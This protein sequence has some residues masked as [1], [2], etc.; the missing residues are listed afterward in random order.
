MLPSRSRYHPSNAPVTLDPFSRIVVDSGSGLGVCPRPCCPSPT[1]T[2]ATHIASV[3]E[4]AMR[5]D[6]PT[7]KIA[8]APPLLTGCCRHRLETPPFRDFRF[9]IFVV[10]VR[11]V[12][13]RMAHLVDGAVAP[14]NPLIRIRIRFVPARVVVPRDQMQNRA[15]GQK[16]RGFVGVDV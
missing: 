15:L 6:R 1:R 11:D 10:E 16:R 12:Q 8:S 14:A 2:P 9:E 13:P 5:A 3:T 7:L 4:P